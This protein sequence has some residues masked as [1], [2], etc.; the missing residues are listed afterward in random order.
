[1][2]L[3]FNPVIEGDLFLWE[4]AF[5]DSH[6]LDTIRKARAIVL[7]QTVSREFY[8]LCRENCPMVFPNYDLRFSWE[9]KIGDT[10]L[11]WSYEMPH[12]ETVVFAKVESLIG[13]HP[14]MMAQP[15]LPPFPFLI[16]GSTGGGGSNIWLI[17]DQDTLESI[18][19]ILK[20]REL[21]GSFGFVIQE[22]LPGLQ[23]DL[24]VVI[25]GKR[26]ISYWRRSD[27][28]LHNVCRGGK[29]DFD[30]DPH[31]QAKGREAVRALCARTGINLAGFDLIFPEPAGKPV[32]LEINYTFG[33]QGIGGSE[34]FY[35]L[36]REA[37]Q[38]WQA[39]LK[40]RNGAGAE[41]GNNRV[42]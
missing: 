6:L 19:K 16:K 13:E 1:M 27:D 36:L 39:E 20:N 41:T 40:D 17:K 33:R 28:L 30:S 22:F 21:E 35:G 37:V 29:I 25:I 38:E 14:G 23:R 3:S 26:I 11:F 32:F 12:P 34:S 7:P 5:W 24:R 10:L 18:L 4:R 9:G 42:S 2:L 15:K 8:R 31:L